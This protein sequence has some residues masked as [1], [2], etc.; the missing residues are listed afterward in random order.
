[1]DINEKRTHRDLESILKSDKISDQNKEDTRDFLRWLE[2][3][4]LS[5]ARKSA[6]FRA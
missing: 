4:E 3:N 1:M 5:D 2:D 6:I